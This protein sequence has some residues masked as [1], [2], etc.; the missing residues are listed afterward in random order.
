[1]L[2]SQ[3]DSDKCQE[4]RVPFLATLKFIQMLQS[5]ILLCWKKMGGREGGMTGPLKRE[6]FPVN[7]QT[8]QVPGQ[9]GIKGTDQKGP[10][11]TSALLH[12]QIVQ[13]HTQCREETRKMENMVLLYRETPALHG[14]VIHREDFK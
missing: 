14:S 13:M 2:A 4:P 10:R 9:E 5:S 8:H 7:W 11:G 3:G 1:M 6:Q 12:L